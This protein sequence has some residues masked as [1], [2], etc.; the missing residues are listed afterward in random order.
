MNLIEL[1]KSALPAD[2]VEKLGPLIGENPE[3]VRSASNAAIPAILAMLA[4]LVSSGGAGTLISVLKNLD[5]ALLGN[6]AKMVSGGDLGTLIKT[7]SGLLNSLFGSGILSALVNILSKSAGIGTDG[8]NNL[9]AVLAPAVLGTIG[10]QAKSQGL[11]A[12]GL[13]SLFADQERNIKAALPAGLSLPE[14]PVSQVAAKAADAASGATKWLWPALGLLALAAVLWWLFGR[15]PGEQVDEAQAPVPAAPAAPLP[16]P[17]EE[18]GQLAVVPDVA[19]LSGDVT[20]FFTSVTETFNSVKDAASAQAAVSKLQDAGTQLDAFKKT[21][22]T[23]PAAGKE[24]IT[25]LVRTGLDKLKELASQALAL[26]GV[27]EL[28][29]PA[30]DQLVAKLESLAA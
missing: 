25:A 3:K 14:L 24:T 5:P 27:Q 22:E 16:G 18:P 15:Q 9:L 19:S 7:G 4:R 1:I 28:L 21:F 2:L 6:L 20:K 17:A 23:L 10:E 30:Y 12:Q 11:T 13:T 26:P 29:K 8:A